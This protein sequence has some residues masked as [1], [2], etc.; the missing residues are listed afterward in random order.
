MGIKLKK[1]GTKW[2]VYV[3]HNGVRKAKCVG[4][5]KAAEEVRRQLEAHFALGDLG[6]LDTR[7]HAPTFEHYAQAWLKK[8]A[9]LECKAS[10]VRSYEQ[11]LRVHVNPR[12]GQKK[13]T[14]IT[15]D[16]IKQ[17]LA[18]LSQATRVLQEVAIPRFA[19]NTLRLIVCS[20]R[21]VLNA[22]VEDGILESNPAARVGR[23]AKS[24]KPARQASAMT[25]AEVD[26]FLS[27][28][29]ELCPEW[30]SFF[31]T[32]L[33]GGLRKGE[34]IA[35]KW[36]DIQFGENP[37]DPN[38]YIIVQRNWSHGRFTS[39]RVISRAVSTSQSNSGPR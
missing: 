1:R 20:L 31:L 35:L 33:R 13:L 18:D 39:Q 15:R 32:A 34:L 11:L 14:E 10:T 25:R 2:Y 26:R 38:R 27:A 37:E 28:V 12:F 9:E 8:Y 29:R 17:F 6:F 21:S 16:E 4:T 24:E 19:R 7:E 23:F 36:G 30:H 5:R 3:N 22:A